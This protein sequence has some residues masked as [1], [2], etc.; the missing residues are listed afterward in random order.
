MAIQL[1]KNV[2]AHVTSVCSSRNFELVNSL[3][4][5]KVI[6]YTIENAETQLET[7]EYVIDAVGNSK[8]S[9]LKRK[10]QKSTYSKWQI[11]IHRSWNSLNPKRSFFEFKN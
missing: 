4:S 5:D 2:G 3:G 7:Y 6:D 11:Y 8:S 10:E 9:T 1:A